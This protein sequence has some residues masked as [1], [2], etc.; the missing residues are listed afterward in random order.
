VASLPSYDEDQTDRQRGRKVFQ[1]SIEGL[2]MLNAVGYGKDLS[3]DLIFNP[4]GPFLPPKQEDLEPKYRK[5][6][7]KHG[8]VFSNLISLCNMPVKRY[9]DYLRKQGTLQGYMEMLVRNF[10]AETVPALMCLNTVS[11]SWTGRV[12]DCDFN[13]QLDMT[14]GRQSDPLTVFNLESLDDAILQ[15]EAI[16]TAAHCY[17]CTAASGSG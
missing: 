5:E 3:L 1:R 10:N 7:A 12:Y 11:V 14:L 13:Q 17:G 16:R 6:M 4:P 2:Q 9:F 8:V 15:K